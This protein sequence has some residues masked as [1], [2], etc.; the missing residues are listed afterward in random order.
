M[1]LI[2]SHRPAAHKLIETVSRMELNS[3]EIRPNYGNYVFEFTILYAS[4][5]VN[6]SPIGFITTHAIGFVCL[7]SACG[8]VMLSNIQRWGMLP[9]LCV[10]VLIAASACTQAIEQPVSGLVTLGSEWT[11]IVPPKPLKVV[12]NEQ[13]IRLELTGISDMQLDNTLEFSDGRRLVID[14]ELTDDQGTVYDLALGGVAAT[15]YAFFYRAGD[16]PPG[17]DYSVDRTIV[18]LRLRSNA[19]IEV[20]EIRWICS[21]TP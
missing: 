3:L 10:L 12:K 4:F 2:L 17:P 21:T 16:Y 1:T 5:V 18:K 6:R 7:L 15:R 11:E 14:A 13:A 19:I 9:S 8:V 20:D